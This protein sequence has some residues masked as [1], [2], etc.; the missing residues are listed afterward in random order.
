MPE[1]TAC[2]KS[3]KG[4]LYL[5]RMRLG[6]PLAAAALLACFAS[7]VSWAGDLK[8]SIPRKGVMTPVQKLNRDGVEAVRKHEYDKA[9]ALFYKAYLYDP[10]DPFTLNNL[11]YVSEMQGDMDRA[12][13]FYA[14]ASEQGCDA[15][16]DMSSLDEL[17]GKPMTYA[18][19]SL[20]KNMKNAPMRVD[21]M[22]FQAIELLSQNQ[23]FEADRLLRAALALEPDDPFTLNNLGVASE[24][25]GD[26][27][28]ALQYYDRAAQSRSN[29]PI[30][31]TMQRS[32]RGKAVSEVAAASA[33]A[34]RK[35]LNG[36]DSEQVRAVMYTTQGVAAA[37]RNDY[38]TAR[39]DFLEAYKL[40][41]AD[42]FSLNNVG[43]VAEKNGDLETA[44]FYYA[45]A[46]QA[47][48]SDARVGLAT[49]A[50]AEGQHLST[51]ASDSD[52]QV[53]GEVTRYRE[54]RQRETG[55]IE[56]IPRDNTQGGNGASNPSTTDGT[57]KAPASGSQPPQ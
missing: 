9:K 7:Q 3:R 54:Q 13:K 15:T 4:E 46:R 34:L 19:V 21:R 17:K 14:L 55:P 56:L 1:R 51:V 52:Q 40:D 6:I 53:G 5:K 27:Q 36:M 50:M 49:Q 48:D 30:I 20:D 38:A 28:D 35:R 11:G 8:I 24:N 32:T 22:N 31:V 43:Y 37:N 44:Q 2:A 23:N 57:T 29:E 47:V 12:Q 16:V 39:Q 10:A 42:A 26:F 18:F 45:K 41:P 25:E 33:K